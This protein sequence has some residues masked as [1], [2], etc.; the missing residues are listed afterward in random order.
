M[1][2]NLFV[3]L[4]TQNTCNYYNH[5]N[6]NNHFEIVRIYRVSNSFFMHMTSEWVY[7]TSCANNFYNFMLLCDFVQVF[8]KGIKIFDNS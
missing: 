7:A 8:F 3:T 2:T 6:Y 5:I 4:V 1:E